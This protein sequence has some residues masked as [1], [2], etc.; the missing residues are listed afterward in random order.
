MIL[1]IGEV[2]TSL[3]CNL[4][5][6]CQLNKIQQAIHKI[7][8]LILESRLFLCK[9]LQLKIIFRGYKSCHE[10]VAWSSDKSENTTH[11]IST[12]F[13]LPEWI[14]SLPVLIVFGAAYLWA[15]KARLDYTLG[16][17]QVPCQLSVTPWFPEHISIE[18][19]SA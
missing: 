2:S 4:K 18:Y 17:S 15:Y 12:H 13:S 6:F 5:Y 14:S 8:L 1:F 19:V 11:L 9:Q 10:S 16:T 3:T 7:H